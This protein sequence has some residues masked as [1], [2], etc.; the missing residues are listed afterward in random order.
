L[1]LTGNIATKYGVNCVCFGL[2]SRIFVEVA[3]LCSSGRN[4]Y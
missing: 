2:K 1:L 4:R 3:G